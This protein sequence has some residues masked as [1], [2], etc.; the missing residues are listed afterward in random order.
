M[1]YIYPA[2]FTGTPSAFEDLVKAEYG[3]LPSINV[4]TMLKEIWH[5]LHVE[6]DVAYCAPK[7]ALFP[8]SIP[9]S[10]LRLR[11][12]T[13]CDNPELP[14]SEYEQRRWY[15]GQIHAGHMR[16]AFD[17]MKNSGPSR[18]REI[19]DEA[20]RHPW[21]G[22]DNPRGAIRAVT[23]TLRRAGVAHY[24]PTTLCWHRRF[25]AEGTW[26]TWLPLN[27]PGLRNATLDL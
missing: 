7:R 14:L 15:K 13:G 26:P 11:P 4:D 25:C 19:S 10:L 21:K 1:P 20:E 12:F 16:L 24:S 5:I 17:R 6:G 9:V 22:M 23:S 18:F 27:P 3:R 2:T 8:L